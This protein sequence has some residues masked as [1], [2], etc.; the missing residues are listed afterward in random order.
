[1][2]PPERLHSFNNK[3][4]TNVQYW[5]R[6]RAILVPPPNTH[7]SAVATRNDRQHVHPLHWTNIQHSFLQLNTH[8]LDPLNNKL[9]KILKLF[10]ILSWNSCW[11]FFLQLDHLITRSSDHPFICQGTTR[12]TLQSDQVDEF[13]KLDNPPLPLPLPPPPFLISSRHSV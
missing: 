10:L 2:K 7:H 4:K 13:Q 3:L 11:R 12:Q 6:F 5:K 8:N 1:M 9:I